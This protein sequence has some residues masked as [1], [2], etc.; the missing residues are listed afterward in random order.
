MTRSTFLS[1]G[2]L[3]CLLAG[4]EG[5][6]E[7]ASSELAADG[8]LA[9][10]VP[11]SLQV[12]AVD[13]SNLVPTVTVNRQRQNIDP[14]EVGFR[15][16]VVIPEGARADI[17]IEWVEIICFQRLPLAEYFI[18]LASVERDRSIRVFAEDY[19]TDQLDIDRDGVSNLA[20][21]ISNTDPFD[22]SD[23]GADFAQVFLPFIDPEDAPDIDGEYDGIWNQAQF[24]DRN[25]FRLDID[26]LMIDQG[27]TRLDGN[28]EYRWA[29][30][31]DGANLYLL[32]FAEGANGQTPFGDSMPDVWNDDV[33]EIFLDG[34]NSKTQ[35]YDGVNDFQLILPLTPFGELAENGS[36]VDNA[37]F[38][39]GFNSAPLDPSSFEFATCICDGAQ[40]LYEVRIDLAAVGIQVDRTFGFELQ[41]DD[42]RDGGLREVKWGWFHPSRDNN[43][44]DNTKDSPQFMSTMR[45]Q[46]P[47][48]EPG[49]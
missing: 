40:Q 32:V 39:L 34:D 22:A 9:L 2:L 46:P 6:G 18:S 21:R 44:V 13:Q 8:S 36:D 17:L 25:R 3:A 30:M 26:N 37:R 12:R 49:S 23:P 4:C 45:L 19:D 24:R 1:A 20:E 27:A 38:L 33:L 35:D 11:P 48:G 42:D 28:T 10:V 47:I 31:H 7:G 15:A 29:A 14:T 16:S 41:L 5:S 43:D